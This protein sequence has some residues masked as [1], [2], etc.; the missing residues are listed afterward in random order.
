MQESSIPQW[1]SKG[2]SKAV[3]HPMAFM[4]FELGT[5]FSMD[6]NFSTIGAKVVLVVIM[7]RF[8]LDILASYSHATAQNFTISSQ[9][10]PQI[11]VSKL[12]PSI[13]IYH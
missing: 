3:K 2:V 5:R 1:F 10:R 8:S 13:E 12:L 4:P 9:Y 6:M 11:I 7:Q